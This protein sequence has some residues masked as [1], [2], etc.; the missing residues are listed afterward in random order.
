MTNNHIKSW[1][2]LSGNVIVFDK[3]NGAVHD[4]STNNEIGIVFF[5]SL[6]F[7]ESFY[8]HGITT[9]TSK[10][11]LMWMQSITDK[12]RDALFPLLIPILESQKL[13]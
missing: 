12:S 11:I 7:H 4:L 13:L 5:S 1:R 2:S 9:A 8:T 6:V 3:Y 10:N